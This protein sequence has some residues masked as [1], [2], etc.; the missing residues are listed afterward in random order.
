MFEGLFQP[1]ALAAHSRDCT[2]R[3]K[4]EEPASVR[5]RIVETNSVESDRQR[6][7]MGTL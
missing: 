3:I 4:P 1:S 6:K 7:N 5:Q 2:I